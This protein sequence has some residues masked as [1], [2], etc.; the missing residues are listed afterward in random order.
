[1]SETVEAPVQVS[2][3]PTQVQESVFGRS[4]WSENLPTPAAQ[5]EVTV[6]VTENA[7]V[8]QPVVEA[9]P[10]EEPDFYTKEF[11][12][13][14]EVFKQEY[15]ELVKFKTQ[16]P[17][18]QFENEESKKLAEAI[19][20]GDKKEIVR[21]LETQER[22]EELTK[23]EVNDAS[24]EEIIKMGMRLKYKDLSSKEIEYKFSKEFGLPKEPAQNIDELDEDFASRKSI[25]QE[26]VDDIK[27][28]RSIEAKLAKPELEKLKST[29]V[30]PEVARPTEQK[31]N[32]PSPEIL[33]Q[34]RD[35]FLEKLNSDYAKVEGYNTKVKD[36]SVEL[37]V[38][39]KIPDEVKAAI[40]GRLTEGMD[41][42]EY[43]DKRW[44]DEKGN[45][46]INQIMLDI[47]Q[48]ENLDKILSSVAN[49]SASKRLHEYRQSLRNPD[50]TS[51]NNSYQ[52]TF[53]QSDN[54]QQKTTPYSKGAWS[55]KPPPIQN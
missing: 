14:K 6:P 16:K 40:K 7:P 26:K 46:N 28:N 3:E 10:V 38:A 36:E 18:Y 39:H 41:V 17:E 34:Q 44:F 23:A 4:A 8:T 43:M 31:A 35:N 9:A 27:M 22:L 21:I 30:V 1:M 48:L 11:G 42:Q 32:E 54:G 12:K 45:A 25:W 49:D 15:D 5:E 2:A 37:P 19:S 13:S 20:K 24:A 50:V 52:Q 51:S 47:Y 29:I 55:E 53:Q 33:K